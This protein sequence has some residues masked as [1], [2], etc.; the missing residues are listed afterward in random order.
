MS[1]IDHKTIN[2]YTATLL[3]QMT[4][5]IVVGYFPGPVCKSPISE[6]FSQLKI[7]CN[8]WRNKLRVNRHKAETD[9]VSNDQALKIYDSIFEM[10]A[11]VEGGSPG[12]IFATKLEEIGTKLKEERTRLDA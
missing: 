8:A 1:D 4:M 6:R 2:V 5:E 12:A 3:Y 9:Q 10:V 7:G 11:A